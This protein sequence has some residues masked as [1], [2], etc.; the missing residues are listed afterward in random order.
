MLETRAACYE[1]HPT[2]NNETTLLAHFVEHSAGWTLRLDRLLLDP[3]AVPHDPHTIQG[4]MLPNAHRA[5]WALPKLD[6]ADLTLYPSIIV[7]FHSRNYL[8]AIVQQTAR[9]ARNYFDTTGLLATPPAEPP[10]DAEWLDPIQ[11]AFLSELVPSA[12]NPQVTMFGEPIDPVAC[13]VAA[14]F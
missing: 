10:A 6:W 4:A 3:P 5:Q 1:S 7:Q 14:K 13:L 11:F 12:W 9:L 2:I 8:V